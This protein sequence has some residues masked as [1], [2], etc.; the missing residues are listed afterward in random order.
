MGDLVYLRG[1]AP[2]AARNQT[3]AAPTAP[4]EASPSGCTCY[5]ANRP[6]S[7]C[8]LHAPAP[9]Y[10]LEMPEGTPPHVANP[11]VC[12]ICRL[13]PHRDTAHHR[14]ESARASIAWARKLGW[15]LPPDQEFLL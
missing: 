7:P 14:F 3:A 13:A 5:T 1:P 11:N 15:P 9:T 4:A 12:D 2:R 10:W 8:P 6:E